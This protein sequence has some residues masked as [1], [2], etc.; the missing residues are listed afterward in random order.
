V[1]KP[2]KKTGD[3]LKDLGVDARIFKRACR[4]QNGRGMISSGSGEK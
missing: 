1:G 4:T 2:E 3:H